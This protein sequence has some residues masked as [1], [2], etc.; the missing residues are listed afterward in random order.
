MKFSPTPLAGAFVIDVEPV[1]DERGFFARSFCVEELKNQRLS[2]NV[3]QC[4]ISSNN[5]AGTLRGLHFQAEPQGEEKIVRCTS[6]ALYDVIVD[7]R[8]MSSTYG[9]WF[10]IELSSDN[11]RS[12]FIPRGF[13]HGFVTLAAATEVFYMIST[14]FVPSLARGL[15]WD[16]P[17]V[18]ISWPLAPVIMSERD[19]NLPRLADLAQDN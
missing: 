12:L 1:A 16:D 13:A 3:L 14:A 18:A 10:G 17:A 15:R 5:K 7:I 2:M 19:A 9:R 4:S 11:H 6:G 8:R